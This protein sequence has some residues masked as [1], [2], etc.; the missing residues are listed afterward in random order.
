LWDLPAYSADDWNLVLS[1]AFEPV[2]ALRIW[3]LEHDG[4]YPETLE[5]L[6]PGL[7]PVLPR[8]PMSGQP[9]LYRRSTGQKLLPL[10]LSGY[11]GPITGDTARSQ[12]TRPGQWLLYSV[13]PNGHDDGARFDYETSAAES[14]LIFPLPDRS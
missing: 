9:F 10:G 11:P 4:R 1:R 12:P 7:L 3:H 8:D 6:V 2:A 5:A 13:G 14:D